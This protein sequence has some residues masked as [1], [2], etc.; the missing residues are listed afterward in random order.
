M[1]TQHTV[2]HAVKSSVPIQLTKPTVQA[3]HHTAE[4]TTESPEAIPQQAEDSRVA[5]LAP[6]PKDLI[7]TQRKARR[8]T[9]AIEHL[10]P[11]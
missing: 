8:V 6:S 7:R 1:T 4:S 11:T 3:K 2:S 10:Q 5:E 9:R